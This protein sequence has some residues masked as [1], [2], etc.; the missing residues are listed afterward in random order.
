[1]SLK[2]K[3]A[4]LIDFFYYLIPKTSELMGEIT[5]NLALGKGIID[6]QPV[7]T[8]LAFMFATVGYAIF[9]FNKKDF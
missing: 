8:S 5:M 4:E 6:W 1:V 9:I 2:L 7:L 3:I